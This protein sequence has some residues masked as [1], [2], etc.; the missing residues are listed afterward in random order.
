M[1]EPE[2]VGA[3]V[4]DDLAG[5]DQVALR[6]RHLR[7][8]EPDHPLREQ[9]LERL[10]Q[11]LRGDAEIGQRL[12]E[13]PRVHEVQHGVLGAAD[14]LVDRH[15]LGDFFGAE[16]GVGIRIGEAQEVPRRVD[17]G[18]HRV[19]LA[20]GRPAAIRAGR[21]QEALVEAQRRLARRPE[22]DVV[23]RQHRQLVVGHRHAC[24]TRAVDDGDRAA[25]EALAA[26]QPVTQAVVDL[27]LADALGFEPVD[28]VAGLR[29]RRPSSPSRKP[30]LMAGPSPVYACAGQ[31]SGR[32]TVSMIGSPNAVAKS[33]SRWSSPGT[34]MIAPVP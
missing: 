21:V 26:D 8:V 6:L 33:Q 13:E 28:G 30:L 34:A 7:A 14:V 29:R 32:A 19:G 2:C 18:V 24:R 9:P 1:R 10:A 17:E 23:G 22:L 15:P 16:R 5:R 20:H 27:A 4:L 11:V 12:G 3:V 31:P 25:P